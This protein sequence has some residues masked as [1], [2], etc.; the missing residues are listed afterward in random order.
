MNDVEQTT[1]TA[2]PQESPESRIK[3]LE[4]EKAKLLQELENTKKGLSTA[5]SKLTEKDKIL[6]SI[7]YAPQL[8]R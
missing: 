3:A 4:D 5:H 7:D 8:P 2:T 1:Q 6:K